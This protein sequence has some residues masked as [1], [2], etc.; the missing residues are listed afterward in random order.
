MTALQMAI[1]SKNTEIINLL[2]QKGS[3]FKEK[4]EISIDL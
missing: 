1:E 2:K 4:V 3:P